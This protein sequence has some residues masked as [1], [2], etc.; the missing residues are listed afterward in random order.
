[1][2][3]RL[4][5]IYMHSHVN[6]MATVFGLYFFVFFDFDSFH[7]LNCLMIVALEKKNSMKPRVAVY[8]P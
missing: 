3:F 5:H 2:E 1:M 6:E 4:R 8:I 7:L